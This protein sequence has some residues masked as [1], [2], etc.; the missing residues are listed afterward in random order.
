MVQEYLDGFRPDSGDSGDPDPPDSG[1]TGLTLEEGLVCDVTF[2]LS[3]VPVDPADVC[4]GC[5]FAFRIQFAL[6]DGDASQCHDPN[7]PEHQEQ[8][9][10]AYHPTDGHVL[11]DFGD[12][13]LWTP[14]YNAAMTGDAVDYLWEVD[15]GV[16]VEE[17]EDE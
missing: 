16:A 13:G 15:V 12:S 14:W 8:W 17:E 10:M 2:A 7:L 9:T 6:L 11:L 1:D 5:D 4:A 3:G